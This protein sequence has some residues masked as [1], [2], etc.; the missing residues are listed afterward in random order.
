MGDGPR[1]SCTEDEE[2]QEEEDMV[3]VNIRRI[4]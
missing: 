2:E 1:R 4:G 3:D